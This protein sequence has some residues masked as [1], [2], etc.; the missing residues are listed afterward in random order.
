MLR[1]AGEGYALRRDATPDGTHFAVFAFGQIKPCDLE[2]SPMA[3]LTAAETRA[4]RI[5][6]V[7]DEENIRFA[8]AMSLEA[9]G[10]KVITHGTIQGALAE[11][12]RQA[13][14]LIFLDVRLGNENGLDYLPALI[15]DN[16]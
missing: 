10:H 4:L 12:A 8:L 15:Q 9:E 14:D 11:T 13:F 3:E 2:W 16:P 1:S 6:V 5:L 7:D